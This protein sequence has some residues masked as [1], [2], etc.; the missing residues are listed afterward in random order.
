ME[1]SRTEYAG[2]NFFWSTVGNIANTIVS[3]IARTIFIYTLGTEYLGIN[4]LFTNVLGMLSLAEL[5]VG[6]A[7]SFSLYKPLA[8]KNIKQI[9]AIINFYRSA[10]RIIAVVVGGIGIC[11]IP[12]LKYIVKGA[13]G[14]PYITFY[15][16][17][18]LFNSVTSYLISYKTTLLSADQ[19]NYYITN[20]N[21]IVKIITVSIQSILLILFKNYFVY[22]IS[23][24][25]IQL[26]SKCYLNYFTDKKYFYIK[27]KNKEV[28]SKE[29]K[30]TIF[31][32]I[33]AL[34]FHKIGD[35]AINQTD[36]IITSAFI[37]IN[38]VGLV[39]NF[40]LIIKMVNTFITAFF[41]SA[42][43][44]LGN[45]VATESKERCLQIYKK[46]DFLAFCFFGWSTVC[47]YFLLTPFITLW[48]GADKIVD[49]VTVTLL[50]INF[51]FTGMR[52]PLGNIKGAAGIYE[53]DK[54]AP[55]LQAAINLVISVV[56][57]KYWG[58][59]GV[60]V[61]TLLSSMV[62]NLIRPYIVYKY[63]FGIRCNTYFK[64]YIKRIFVLITCILLLHVFYGYIHIQSAW[65]AFIVR[66]FLAAIVPVI[67]IYFVYRQSEEC[68]YVKAILKKIIRK[69]K[70]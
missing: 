9:Q 17:I 19:K 36:D 23:D 56:G 70:S 67:I 39:S 60:Y 41:N 40:T 49:S 54:F 34:L 69:A 43:A 44:G 13:E 6:S 12:F 55:V 8:E 59:K 28:L 61:G 14:I 27:G 48:I 16:I 45:I 53:P 51:Y 66:A 11:L 42:T 10:Y 58:L 15:Y 65:I 3:F 37:N 31:S 22:L 52:V 4:G 47:L 63:I 30:N 50:C 26:I 35:V 2:K 21:T 7:I 46:Y 64:E 1:K 62:P 29:E 68:A 18:F 32:K 25:V 57:A 38:T 33:K 5:G 20:I 24:A